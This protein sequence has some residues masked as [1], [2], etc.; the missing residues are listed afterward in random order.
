MNNDFSTYCQTS[1]TYPDFQPT[2]TAT[3][4]GVEAGWAVMT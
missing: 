3:S 4:L 1:L 2:V